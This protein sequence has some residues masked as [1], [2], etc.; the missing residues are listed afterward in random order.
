MKDTPI[1]PL[2]F[3]QPSEDAIR[4]YAYHLYQQGNCVPGHDLDNWLE[5]TACL[6]A[7]VPPHEA[8]TRLHRYF[9]TVEGGASRVLFA[10][11]KALS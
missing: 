3:S 2:D 10:G 4:D 5:A 8:G 11:A 6:K 7:N 9:K 1:R